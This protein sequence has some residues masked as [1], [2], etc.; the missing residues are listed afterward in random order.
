MPVARSKVTIINLEG[1]QIVSIGQNRIFVSCLLLLLSF[2]LSFRWPVENGKITSVFGESRGDHF[3]DGMDVISPDNKIY[4][5]EEGDLVYMWN[6]ALFPLDNYAGGGNYKILKHKNDM[7]SLYLHL[8]DSPNMKEVYTVNDVLGTAG[9]T[10]RSYG[11]HLHFSMVDMK[12][13]RSENPLQFAAFTGDATAP[14]IGDALVRI[15]D[16]YTIIKDAVNIRLTKH[17]PLLIDVTDSMGG[18]EKLGIYRL[19]VNFNSAKVLEINFSGIDSSKNGLTICAK[20]FQDL[21]DEKGYY[22]V[23]DISYVEGVNTLQV[24]ASDFQGNQAT[25]EIS[26]NVKLDIQ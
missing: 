11:R 2:N 26:F 23:V 20:P 16:S 15:G 10:G 12:K 22:K 6:R 8:E 3:H 21:Y 14:K 4:P 17:Y 19:C 1:D 13:S 18:R 7:Y 24:I 25:K 9:N 5:T